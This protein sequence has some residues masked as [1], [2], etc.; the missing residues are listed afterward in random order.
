[1]TQE[2]TYICFDFGKKR[3]G[4]AVGQTLTNTASPL[5]TVQVKKG[6]PDWD[7]ITDLIEKWQPSALIVGKPLNMDGTGQKMT[8]AANQFTKQLQERYNLPVY[9]ADERLSSYE[10]RQ[11]KNSDSDLDPVAAQA[12]L[13]T[14]LIENSGKIN[15]GDIISQN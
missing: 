1:V 13:E 7:N 8:T 5:C 12:I 14:W 9:Q 15:N 11:R 3:I 4:V 10:A 6:L 2:N